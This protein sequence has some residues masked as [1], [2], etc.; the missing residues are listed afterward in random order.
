MSRLT[1]GGYYYPVT[2]VID[3]EGVVRHV[4]SSEVGVEKHVDEALEALQSTNQ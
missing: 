4:F 3:E 1:R 2:Y